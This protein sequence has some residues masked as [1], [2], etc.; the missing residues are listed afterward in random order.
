MKRILRWLLIL[1]LVYWLGWNLE[2]KKLASAFASLHLHGILFTLL[3]VTLS[4]L[5][6]SYRW[7]YLG[8]SRFGFLS[9]LD[10]N[11]IAFVLNI[12]APAKL[13]DLSKVYYLYKKEGCDPHYGMAL[14]FIERI[15]DVVVLAAMLLASAL[16]LVPDKSL[17]L[18]AI[19]LWGGAALLFGC[20]ASRRCVKKLLGALPSRKIRTAIYKTVL[21]L[22]AAGSTQRLLGAFLLTLLLWGGYYLNNIVF[23]LTATDFGL[24]IPQIVIASTLAFAVSAIPLT[25]G[26]IGTFQAAFVLAL[27]WYGIS[28]EEAL[29]ASTTLQ[30]LYVLPALLYTLYLL[31]K[32]R[33]VLAR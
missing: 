22:Q 2:W 21:H 9:C 1:A 30:I 27:G 14:F 18:L 16:L 29:A 28:K 8:G 4:D 6:I 10:A 33:H 15:L 24:S 11:M 25:P 31:W 12:F 5:L 3:T 17:A 32:D 7:Y 26:G 20:I 23:F 13:G 19:S